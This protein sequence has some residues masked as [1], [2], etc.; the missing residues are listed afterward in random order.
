M[1]STSKSIWWWVTRITD[2]DAAV[3]ETPLPGNYSDTDLLC[4]SPPPERPDQEI[5]GATLARVSG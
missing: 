3:S 5:T 4:S 1:A 2:T